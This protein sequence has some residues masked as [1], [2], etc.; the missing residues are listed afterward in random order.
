MS[1]CERA[2]T[3]LSRGLSSLSIRSDPNTPDWP[4]KLMSGESSVR[5]TR[6]VSQEN[7]NISEHATDTLQRYLS[8][9]IIT[10]ATTAEEGNSSERNSEIEYESNRKNC[11]TKTGDTCINF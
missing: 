10:N 8:R 5:G 4:S 3:N 9:L 11:R 6:Q 1:I 7:D 2:A